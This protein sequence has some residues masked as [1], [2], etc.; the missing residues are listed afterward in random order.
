M[1][2]RDRKT[3]EILGD[4]SDD[5]LYDDIFC[6][7]E[8][9][10]MAAKLKLTEDDTTVMFSLDGA[11]LYQNKKSDT[12]MAI[13]IVA[14]YD[15]NT[16]YK[17]KHVLPA[18]II[19]GPNKPKSLESFLHRGFHHLSAIQRENEG[20]GLRVWDYCKKRVITTRVIHLMSL[21][22]A[23]GLTELDG[24]VG[25]HGCKGCRLGCKMKGRHKPSSGHYYSVHLRPNGVNARDCN[26]PDFDFRAPE[27]I[28][29]ESKDDYQANLKRIIESG[30]QKTY[31]NNR[32]MTGISKP[33]LVSGL[34]YTIPIPMC[35]T[36]DLMHL[37]FL[38]IGDL[39]IPLWRGTAKCEPTDKKESWDWA[40]LTGDTWLAHGKLVANLTQYFPS[41]F[42]RPPRN[43]AEKINS[44]YKATEYA[45]YIYGLGPSVF[46][47]VLPKKYWK[48]VCK[49]VHG[50]RIILQRRIRQSQL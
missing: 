31:E 15:P 22:D 17:K 32:K 36:V 47:A 50:A 46:R 30:D 8:F 2:Y 5:P 43:P 21:A 11:Q 41:S 9:L 19:P 16:R 12:W 26:H 29:R 13:Y 27:G 1:Q 14:N 49:L 3:Q 45:L 4:I 39:L 28:K 6:G 20:A 48:N 18:L 24:R 44:G 10:D 42:H 35:F 34:L 23:L 25:H 33:S 40:K 37:L 7:Q 38:N